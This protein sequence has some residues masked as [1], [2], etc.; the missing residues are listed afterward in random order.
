[1]GIWGI[2]NCVPLPT[3]VVLVSLLVHVQADKKSVVVQIAIG[4]PVQRIVVA[5]D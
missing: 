1:M 4:Q 3:P 5:V 2:S